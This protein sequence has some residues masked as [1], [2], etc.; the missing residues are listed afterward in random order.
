MKALTILQ[1]H[2]AQIVTPAGMLPA[3]EVPKRV[4]NRSWYTHYRGPVMIHAGLSRQ[5]L[6]DD[7]GTGEATEE[8]WADAKVPLAFGALVGVAWIIDCISL[9][10]ARKPDCR[11]KWVKKHAHTM[12][13]FCLLLDGCRPLVQPL[14]TRGFQ[15]FWNVPGELLLQSR[16]Y[17]LTS[18]NLIDK[19]TPPG[20]VEAWR[21]WCLSKRMPFH[22][23]TEA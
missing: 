12:G 8:H 4:E 11:H 22:E 19:R 2:A 20:T 14:I 18:N 5:C 7:V 13:P 16:V 9:D 6:G 17:R 23:E 21:K 3:G 15:K 10:D 1:P